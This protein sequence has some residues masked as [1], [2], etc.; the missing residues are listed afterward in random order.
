MKSVE[1]G[2]VAIKR[3]E[4]RN[5]TTSAFINPSDQVVG[6]DIWEDITKPTMYAEF[7]FNDAIGLLETFPIIGEE[8]LIVE[9]QS[10]GLSKSATF[11]F[12]S[13]E[14]SKISRDI[15]G[16]SVSF[17][18][19]CVSEEH[20]YNGSSVITQ[21]YHDVI[22][23]IV[24]SILVKYLHTN[25]EVIVD[26]T[27]GINML[28]IPKLTPLEAI[29]MCRQR[30]VSKDY[31]SSAY[32]FFENQA[33]FNFKTIEGL[34]KAGKSQIGS[35]VFNRQQDLMGSPQAQANAFRTIL[36]YANI[37]RS[38]SNQKAQQGIFK[39]VTTTFDL[40]T[41]QFS[42]ASF[43]LKNVFNSFET[44]G[45]NKQIP[46]TDDFIDQYASGAPKRT[47]TPKNTLADDTFI[48]TALAARNAY[49]QL[50]NSDITRVMVH[51]DT[52][53]K[54]GDIVTLNLP[55][56]SGMTNRK[57]FEKI[58]SGNFLILRLRH[59]VDQTTKLKHRI[60]FDAVRMG[61]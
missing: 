36:E 5:K 23:N 32:V 24:P 60:V 10:P 18:L 14:V 48:D 58:T 55:E 57:G 21:S 35:R 17:V 56:A 2:D 15:N 53:M 9:I 12:R 6:F 37:A 19:R 29:D 45:K 4:L 8:Q 16:K 42:T 31:V 25:K 52:G 47:F 54:V 40:A 59:I 39:A 34:I 28:A 26:Q 41:K 51:G 43:N 7:I 22:S 1:V 50:L 38:D 49:T 30:A 44:P 20:L 46:N 13:F 61:I 3:L 27:K 11:K 33:G